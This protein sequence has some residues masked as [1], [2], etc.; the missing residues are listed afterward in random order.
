MAFLA[1]GQFTVLRMAEGTGLIGVS[2][3]ALD[4]G[5]VYL[6]MTTATNLLWFSEAKGNVQRVMGVGM[7]A[8]T[9]CIL[10]FCTMAFL[11]MAFETRR[12]FA[13]NIMARCAGD[14]GIVL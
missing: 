7:A 11:V 3:L 13:M 2:G 5:I 1:A 14:L 6:G 12:N 10:K 9:I 4:Q 8:Q